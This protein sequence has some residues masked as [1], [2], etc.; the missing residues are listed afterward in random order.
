MPLWS[1]QDSVR[2][3]DCLGG[4]A[5]FLVDLPVAGVVEAGPALVADGVS[6]AVRLAR[7]PSRSAKERRPREGTASLLAG[8]AQSDVD[9]GTAVRVRHRSDAIL[10]QRLVQ[11]GHFGDGAGNAGQRIIFGAR[12]GDIDIK[13]R[14]TGRADC[15]P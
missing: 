1:G 14:R 12:V 8:S 7:G 11:H 10:D 15:C 13:H 6:G 2:T 3:S 5:A 4:A 9:R